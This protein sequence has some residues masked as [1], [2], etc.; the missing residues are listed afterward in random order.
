MATAFQS[1]AYSI[2][3]GEIGTLFKFQK[4]DFRGIGIVIFV[5]MQSLKQETWKKIWWLLKGVQ[6]SINRI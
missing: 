5:F 4:L 6:V 1:D 2:K 3:E